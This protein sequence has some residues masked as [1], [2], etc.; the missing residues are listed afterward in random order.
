MKR[1]FSVSY[2]NGAFN[3][4]ML[5]LRLAFGGIM[6]INHGMPKLMKFATLQHGFYN[7]MGIGSKFSLMLAIFAEV[8]CALFLIL[9]LLTRISVIPLL[10][11]IGVILF[12]VDKGKSLLASET[13]VLYGIGYLVILFCGPGRISIDGMMRK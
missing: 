4:S 10:I 1:L 9:G 5:L 7:F 8:F 2:S 13:A 3:F 11:L 12:G 6:L